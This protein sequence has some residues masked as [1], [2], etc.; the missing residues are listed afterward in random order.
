MSKWIYS[1]LRA[2]REEIDMGP[3]DTEA[4]AK[5]HM[6]KHTSFGAMCSG[7]Q[8]VPDDYKPYKG[9]EEK[10]VEREKPPW[11]NAIMPSADTPINCPRYTDPAPSFPG[12]EPCGECSECDK[13]HWAS[14]N[15]SP[16]PAVEEA[17]HVMSRLMD[18]Q[19]ARDWAE[20][21]DEIIRQV[22]ETA[23]VVNPDQEQLRQLVDENPE[24][25]SMAMDI[26][27]RHQSCYGKSFDPVNRYCAECRLSSECWRK[28]NPLEPWKPMCFGE[29]SIFLSECKDCPVRKACVEE[30]NKGPRYTLTP[31][32]M[33][34]D[35]ES[36][37]LPHITADMLRSRL[38]ARKCPL[39]CEE[40]D[41]S[42]VLGQPAH[43]HRLTITFNAAHAV[44]ERPDLMDIE[45][46]CPKCEHRWAERYMRLI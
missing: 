16:Q 44:E 18:E 38:V 42:P 43:I 7:P 30:S 26:L 27:Q 13:G 2:D 24:V 32:P 8:E 19:E 10:P 29:L 9:P 25:K 23:K 39:G 37:D 20:G 21:D 4:E 34:T 33:N 36:I 5:R 40:Q 22:A 14:A 28:V 35:I 41:G 12:N 3:Y 11:C 46:V 17:E 15:R 31:T 1:Y 45:L 6:V